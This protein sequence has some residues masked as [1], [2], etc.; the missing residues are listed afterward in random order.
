MM[1]AVD[2]L[3]HSSCSRVWYTVCRLVKALFEVIFCEL[4]NESYGL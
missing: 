1:T 2:S 4:T 3:V